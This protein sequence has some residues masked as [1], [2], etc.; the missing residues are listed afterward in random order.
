M[1]GYLTSCLAGAS[2]SHVNWV[3]DAEAPKL[4]ASP[5]SPRYVPLPSPSQPAQPRMLLPGSHPVHPEWPYSAQ[6]QGH[7]HPV[8]RDQLPLLLHAPFLPRMGVNL[9]WDPSNSSLPCLDQEP[10]GSL[11]P[12]A[13]ASEGR[14]WC[15]SLEPDP[16]GTGRSF[17]SSPGK[18]AGCALDHSPPVLAVVSSQGLS[19][20]TIPVPWDECTT[21]EPLAAGTVT[22]PISQIKKLRLSE[23]SH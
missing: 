16:R 6:A 19:P 11:L 13:R 9:R 18:V 22:L 1:V 5:N 12:E 4:A 17:T 10:E 23:L 21:P 8:D 15:P 20:P 7:L 14:N 2:R 3:P